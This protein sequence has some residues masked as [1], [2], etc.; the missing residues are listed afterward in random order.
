MSLI[1]GCSAAWIL[2]WQLFVGTL[3]WIIT[4]MRLRQARLAEEEQGE[5][6]RL[7]AERAAGGARGQLFDEDEIQAFT[8]R[9]RLRILD[10]YITPVFSLVIALGLLVVVALTLLTRIIVRAVRRPASHG[11]LADVR[12]RRGDVR[13]SSCRQVRRGHVETGRMAALRAAAGF[14]M[15]NTLFAAVHGRGARHGAIRYRGRFRRPGRVL[16]CSA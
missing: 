9:N 14:M 13:L 2:A 15:L 10:K 1:A 5:W 3:V 4:L 8:A 12:L 6:E 7:Q 16:R 11:V